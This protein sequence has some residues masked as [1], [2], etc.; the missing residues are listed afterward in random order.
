MSITVG[1]LRDKTDLYSGG[2][3]EPGHRRSLWKFICRSIIVRAAR[4]IVRG[5]P[6]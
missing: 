4:R 2:P 1:A 6:G 5:R 3:C